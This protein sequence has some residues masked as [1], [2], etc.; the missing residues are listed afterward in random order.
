MFKRMGAIASVSQNSSPA[1]SAI[2]HGEAGVIPG[3]TAH[4]AAI[5]QAPG[6]KNA[7][8]DPPPVKAS[9]W[10]IVKRARM[11]PVLKTD[12]KLQKAL[13]HPV[14]EVLVC[15]TILVNVA[16]STC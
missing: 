2:W 15:C 5:Q 8:P 7:P 12:G 16:A 9:K 3:F 14:T 6:H 13:R 10:G 11:L 4:N 1:G